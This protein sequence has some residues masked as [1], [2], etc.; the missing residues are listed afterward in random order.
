MKLFLSILLIITSTEIY[1]RNNLL[2]QCL[3]KEEEK[4]HKEKNHS[5]LYQL[6]QNFLNEVATN[7]DISLK[8]N[9]VDEICE[10]KKNSPSVGFLRLLLLKES[11]LYDFT[12]SETDSSM[13]S[14]K[15]GYINEFQKQ[16]PHLLFSYLSG[17]QA[18]IKDAHC[19]NMAIPEIKILSEKLK[20]LEEEIS[21]HRIVSDKKKIEQIFI[22]LQNFDKIKEECNKKFEKDLQ[23]LMEKNKKPQFLK[24]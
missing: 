6:N 15:L 14:F 13:R 17:L 8:K 22:K 9:Y 20:Y 11:D 21:I 12:L 3:A 2:L 10:S 23:I 7:N 16:V 24:N 19:L 18:E 5:A 1:G 4:L